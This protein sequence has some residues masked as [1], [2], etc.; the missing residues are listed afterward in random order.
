[1]MLRFTELL[2]PGLREAKRTDDA[3]AD[4][5]AR[6]LVS[7]RDAATGLLNTPAF[8]AVGRSTLGWAARHLESVSV[9]V[10]SLDEHEQLR[11]RDRRDGAISEL[12]RLAVGLLDEEDLA[13]RTGE[14]EVILLLANGDE[15]R[16]DSVTAELCALLQR[17]NGESG[18]ALALSVSVANATVHPEQHD[19]VFEHVLATTRASLA[20]LEG[21]M[22]PLA[23][24]V[25]EVVA[26]PPASTPVRSHHARMF[27]AVGSTV[28]ARVE[29]NRPRRAG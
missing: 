8:T 22:A 21:A 4:V 13:A 5:A 14:R 15:R 27:V 7:T 17:R 28:A 1:M 29:R 10:V 6:R 3:R 20:H 11:D 25:P 19:V 2:A 18:A 16:R 12:A 9:I 24:E 23:E 26:A